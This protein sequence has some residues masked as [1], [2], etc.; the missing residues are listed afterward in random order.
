MSK[1]QENQLRNV[2]PSF[3]HIMKAP[4]KIYLNI[5]ERTSSV[6]RRNPTSNTIPNS[7]EVCNTSTIDSDC[8]LNILEGD[9]PSD[10][11]GNMYICQCLGSP[12]AFMSGDTNIVKLSFSK[13]EVKIKNRF[14]WN[15]VAMARIALQKSKHR[16]DHMG[17]LYMSPG[18]GMFSYTEGM[19]LLPDGRLGITSDVDRPWIID[20]EHLRVQGPV[21]KRSEWIPMMPEGPALDIMGSLFAG[22]SNSHVIYT[23]T[24][25]NE[26]FLVNYRLKMADKEH[27]CNLMKWD[28]K[29]DFKTWSVVD[30]TGK[31]IC[32][33]QSIHELIFT[34]DYI[35][36]ADTAFVTG[37]EILSPWENAPLPNEKT[38]VYIVD[39]RNL[40]EDKKEV[41]A[42]K[43]EIDEACIHLIADY[44]NPNDILT[45]YML[46]T[47]ATNTAEIIR[48]YDKDL[49][50]KRFAKH[51][52]GYGTLPPLDVSSLGKHI[53]DM[54]SATI[55]KSEYIRDTKYCWGPYMYTYMGRQTKKFQDQDLFVHFK[56]F[57]KDMLPKRIYNAYKNVRN[58]HVS[59]SDMIKNEAVG[60][61]NSIARIDKK[62]FNIADVYEMPNKVLI[63]TISCIESNDK[64]A[65]GYILAGVACDALENNKTSGHEYWLFDAGNLSQGPICKIGHESL[66][67]SILFHTVYIRDEMEKK[68]DKKTVTYNISLR[69]DYPVE[70]VKKW[71]PEVL[72]AFEKIIWPYYDKENATGKEVAEKNLK[73]FFNKRHEVPVGKEH[74]IGEE[75][76]VDAPAFAQRMFD[77]ANRIF[78]TTGWK[79]V[80]NQNGVLVESKPV[81]GQFKNSGVFLTRAESILDANADVLFRYMTSAKGY[82]VIDPVSDPEDHNKKPLEIYK[83]KGNGRLEAALATTNIPN[84]PPHDFVVLNAIDSD[85]RIFASKSIQHSAMPGSSIYSDAGFPE[86]GHERAINTFVIKIVPIDDLRCKV[87]CI[88][89]A[90]LAGKTSRLL[91]NIINQRGFFG[92]LYKRMRMAVNEL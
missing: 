80:S 23:D 43:I 36:L 67:N 19:Y 63:Y 71:R 1:K 40:S 61:N 92:P 10:I 74:L 77:E 24:E 42:K 41:I 34:R 88:N 31:N 62:N 26:L 11:S 7:Y 78:S 46:H 15:P 76:L 52:V 82:A 12:E 13:K 17:L 69:E 35:L 86:C 72:K 3:R 70:E 5:K 57:K 85:E 84:L 51:L 53:I 49:D 20:R 28:G 25:T 81:T 44:E 66:N 68:L 16:F 58:R 9:Y 2:Y 87:Y 90:D 29:S 45:V 4:R 60:S 14:F 75:L 37:K 73:S 39:R 56:G 59:L 50:G 32:V 22:Y 89:F 91:N 30:E 54:K 47:P 6:T 8:T 55:Q 83:W 27:P 64:N 38:V 21:G 65:N 48:S 33:E 79:K 18:M